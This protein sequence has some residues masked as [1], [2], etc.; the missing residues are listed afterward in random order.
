MTASVAALQTTL[1]TYP[2][3]DKLDDLGN[4]TIEDSQMWKIF[5]IIAQESC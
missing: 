5:R 4:V 1:T 3:D 2:I